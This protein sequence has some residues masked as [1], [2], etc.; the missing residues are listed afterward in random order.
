MALLLAEKGA[1]IMNCQK[2]MRKEEHSRNWVAGSVLSR[3]GTWPQVRLPASV[4][5]A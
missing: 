4:A 5:A 1:D 2:F 3:Y